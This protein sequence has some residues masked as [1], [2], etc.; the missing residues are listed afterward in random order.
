MNRLD[1][2]AAGRAEVV[3]LGADGPDRLEAGKTERRPR[4]RGGRAYNGHL[5]RRFFDPLGD[6]PQFIDELPLDVEWV[7]RWRGEA[8]VGEAQTTP[9]HPKHVCFG[10]VAPEPQFEPIR[11]A[12]PADLALPIDRPRQY[13]GPVTQSRRF[14]ESFFGGESMH[15]IG[16]RAQQRGRILPE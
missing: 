10:F 2:G 9:V 3:G 4:Q 6:A 8:S 1:G 13:S 16:Q 14:L 12:Q 15:T 7:S 5:C 11:L